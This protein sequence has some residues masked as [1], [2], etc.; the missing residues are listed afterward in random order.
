MTEP[1]TNTQIQ[2]ARYGTLSEIVLAIAQ[3]DDLRRLK[4][5]ASRIKW[6]LDFDRCTL[7]LLDPD[8]Q[9]YGLQTLL[10]T[11]RG[12]QATN[13]ERVPLDQGLPGTVMRSRQLQLV[14]ASP[15]ERSTVLYPVDLAVWDGSWRRCCRCRSRL[16]VACWGR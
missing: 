4:Q 8:G 6:V 3:T 13:L 5:I 14:S 10:E 1:N 2:A 12:V 7:A 11:R 16:Q 9:G 15:A